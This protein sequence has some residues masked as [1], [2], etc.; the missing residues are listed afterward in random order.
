MI[1][2]FIK[3]CTAGGFATIVHY[4][5]FLAAINSLLWMPWQA[6]LLGATAGALVAYTLNYRYTFI[7]EAAHSKLLPRFFTVAAIGIIIQTLIVAIFNQHW[8]LHYLAAQIIA[9]AT[10]LIL[11][12]LINRFW[13]FT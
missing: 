6:T 13:T 4:L 1:K 3:Y 2:E 12:F 8:H 9:T 10:G 5:V 7:S 11:T